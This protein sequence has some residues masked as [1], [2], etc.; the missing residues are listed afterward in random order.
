MDKF[1][2]YALVRTDIKDEMD[3]NTEGNEEIVSYRSECPDQIL[4]TGEHL[5]EMAM[6]RRASVSVVLTSDK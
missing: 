4:V 3:A 2:K 6:I 5:R 1:G